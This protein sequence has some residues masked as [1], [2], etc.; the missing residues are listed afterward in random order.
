MCKKNIFY[1]V[2]LEP[3]Y[4]NSIYSPKIH[5]NKYVKYIDVK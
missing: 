5:K 1:I 4:I 2:I 3:G